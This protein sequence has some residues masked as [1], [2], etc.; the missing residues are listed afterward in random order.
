MFLSV[1][2]VSKFFVFFRVTYTM[3]CQNEVLGKPPSDSYSMLHICCHQHVCNVEFNIDKV[4]VDMLVLP[5]ICLEIVY[6]LAE[7]SGRGKNEIV[8][9]HQLHN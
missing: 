2:Y 6:H 4:L 9:V 1:T 5:L 3:S 8:F 7:V